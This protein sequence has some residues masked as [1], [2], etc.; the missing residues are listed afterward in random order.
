MA[1]KKYYIGSRGPFFY[2]D[3]TPI[4]DP[5]GDFAGEDNCALVT[6]GQA[7]IG[8]APVNPN[9]V[10]RLGDLPI[11]SVNVTFVDVTGSRAL[12]VTYQNTGSGVMIVQISIRLTG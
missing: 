9:E 5:D 11:G 10:V 12:G 7:L 6:D 4:D 8:Q 2:D 1:R 3:A